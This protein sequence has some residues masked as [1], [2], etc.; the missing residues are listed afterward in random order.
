MSCEVAALPFQKHA[1]YGTFFDFLEKVSRF[2]IDT[3]KLSEIM[4]T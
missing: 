3:M 2:K 4:T 1:N